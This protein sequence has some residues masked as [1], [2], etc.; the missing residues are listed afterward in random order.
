MIK[1]L[2]LL[3]FIA[4]LGLLTAGSGR[5]SSSSRGQEVL[6]NNQCASCHARI[7]NPLSLSNKYYEWHVS[8]HR[9]QGVG[10]ER[11]H[12]GDPRTAD[13]NKAHQQVFI[14]TDPRSKVHPVQLP[15][16]CKEC[17][18]AVVESF[19]ESMHYQKLK[20]SN[21]GPSCSTCHGHMASAVVQD[22]GEAAALCAR[23]HNTVNGLMPARPEIPER[24]KEMVEAISRA[25]GV[26]V[27]ADRLLDAGQQKQIDL[28]E[29]T[30]D[31]KSVRTALSEAKVDWH[32][33]KF[34][35]V[36]KKADDSFDQ[37]T[38]LKDRLLQKVYRQPAG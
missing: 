22:A 32:A 5:S 28:T 26:I 21:L 37:G 8:L 29:E 10:C 23:C 3:S 4:L 18:G 35:L 1:R 11:C 33:L 9:D 7:A 16:T 31:L 30:K 2:C 17:H 24:A 36:R 6:S 13:K 25:N 20:A 19:V 15:D 27:W 38:R 12:G 14:S 34:D